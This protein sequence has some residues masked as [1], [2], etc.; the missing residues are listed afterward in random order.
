MKMPC[1]SES[2]MNENY[3]RCMKIVIRNRKRN[4]IKQFLKFNQQQ[5]RLSF[6]LK[7][8]SFAMNALNETQSALPPKQFKST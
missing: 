6:D 1:K 7:N 8:L 2:R 5:I 3:L 4:Q